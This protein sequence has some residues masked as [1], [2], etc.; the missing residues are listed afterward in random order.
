M[1]D[2][3]ADSAALLAERP[4]TPIFR[5]PYRLILRFLVAALVLQTV[6]ARGLAPLLRAG[7]GFKTPNQLLTAAT[8]L[9][10]TSMLPMTS[11]GD[12]PVRSI[13]PTVPALATELVIVAPEASVAVTVSL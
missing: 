7:V 6:S 9:G 12:E 1:L 13:W 2:E 8:S 11:I 10:L 5:A 3:V 4:A